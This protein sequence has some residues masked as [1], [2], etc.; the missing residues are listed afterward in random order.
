MS[1]FE[2]LIEFP[3]SL[4]AKVVVGLPGENGAIIFNEALVI[5]CRIEVLA[6]H[7]VLGETLENFFGD[8]GN[9]I[10]GCDV[11][12]CGITYNHHSDD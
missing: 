1:W 11:L 6:E 10:D 3:V 9:V 7:D 8:S 2:N 4:D 12:S 5:S